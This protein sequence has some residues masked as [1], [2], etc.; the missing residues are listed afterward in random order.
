MARHHIALNPGAD[1]AGFDAQVTATGTMGPTNPSSASL[2]TAVNQTSMARL[3]SLN[4]I[5]DL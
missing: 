1:L 3:I 5:N 4:G 2:N